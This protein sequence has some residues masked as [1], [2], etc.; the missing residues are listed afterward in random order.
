MPATALGQIGMTRQ[1]VEYS[2]DFNG[3][4]LSGT[5]SWEHGSS[6][7]PGWTVG[8]SVVAEKTLT[9]GV[10]NSQTGGLYS[11]GLNGSSDRALG[12]V[13]SLNAGEF[14]YNL[15]LHN[16]A[17][18]SIKSLEISYYGE[19][20]RSGSIS[21]PQHSIT[22]WYAISSTGVFNL[23]PKADKE[24]VEVPQMRF[25]GKV[26]YTLGGPLNGNIPANRTFLST[27]L[28]VEI[29]EGHYV[30]LRWK[31]ADE[32]EMDHGLGIDDVHVKWSV[33]EA[34]APLPVELISFTAKETNK[35]VLLDWAT[36]F[37]TNNRFFDVERSADGLIFQAVGSVNGSGSTTQT[38]HYSFTDSSPL[39][40][41]SYYRLKQVDE[42]GSF[43]YSSIVP[44]ERHVKDSQGMVYPTLASET[45]FVEPPVAT[46][47]YSLKVTNV[48]GSTELMQSLPE[49]TST[50]H[51]LDISGLKSGSYFLILEDEQGRQWTRR[52]I[53]K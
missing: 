11:Y 25:Y 41:T 43:T 42:D 19:Q 50:V 34:A 32:Y 14:T 17:G 40:G 18:S 8:R 9:A 7:I 3:L 22:F 44:V 20:W 28:P 6:Y 52:F 29:P 37:E 53:K 24:W 12:S 51:Q 36:A 30:M 35:A 27:I 15:L 47:T 33:S 4:P 31:D 38:T 5:S 23:S 1:L 2:Q 16:K 45:L 26:F 48:V 49:S 13:T 21:T 10:G 46:A 39:T